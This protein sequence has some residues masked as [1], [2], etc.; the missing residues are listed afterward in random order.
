M[1][2]CESGV[3]VSADRRNI[4]VACLLVERH[5]FYSSS[6]IFWFLGVEERIKC[7]PAW[8]ASRNSHTNQSN[9]SPNVS[10]QLSTREKN[11]AVNNWST[12]INYGYWC[13]CCWQI[14][15]CCVNMSITLTSFIDLLQFT[16]FEVICFTASYAAKFKYSSKTKWIISDVN[17]LLPP[18][19]YL[20][21]LSCLCIMN[22]WWIV[23]NINVMSTQCYNESKWFCPAVDGKQDYTMTSQEW[24][25]HIC[26]WI[27]CLCLHLQETYVEEEWYWVSRQ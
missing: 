9:A 4:K 5:F 26:C 6:L 17:I 14:N 22:S 15:P 10:S 20:Q 27:C 18:H 7:M 3:N 16:P 8:L 21:N 24:R 2:G 25:T 11:P 19:Y 23:Y 1:A 12:S 13:V